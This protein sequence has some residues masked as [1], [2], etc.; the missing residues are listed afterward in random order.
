MFTM[1]KSLYTSSTCTTSRCFDNP[2]VNTIHNLP[3][4][5]DPEMTNEELPVY[6]DT[7]LPSY[8]ESNRQHIRQHLIGTA[9]AADPNHT[10]RLLEERLDAWM[11]VTQPLREEI[12]ALHSSARSGSPYHQ[13]VSSLFRATLSMAG[14]ISGHYRRAVD[15]AKQIACAELQLTQDSANAR[16]FGRELFFLRNQMFDIHLNVATS[17]EQ[18]DMLRTY[19]R[20]IIE[21]GIEIRRPRGNGGLL[22]FIFGN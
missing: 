17:E 20:E 9:E 8:D 7:Y 10:V 2:G 4:D 3:E 21:L 13:R 15:I 18:Q 16:R 22:G 19:W 6:D 1:E 12:L 5:L 11:R 14:T